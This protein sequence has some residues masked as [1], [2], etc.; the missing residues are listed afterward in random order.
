MMTTSKIAK[1][2]WLIASTLIM[3]MVGLAQE[4]QF[5]GKAEIQIAHTDKGLL[6]YT[7]MGTQIDAPF[8]RI[9]VKGEHQLKPQLNLVYKYEVQVKGFEQDDT[10]NPFAARNTYLGVQSYLGTLL[11][12]RNDTRFKYSEGKFDLFNE[13]QGDIA[14]VI[15]GQD[16]IGDTITYVVPTWYNTEISMTYAPKDDA[17]SQ[18]SGY[19]ITAIYGD[20]S[21]QTLPY[22]VAVS[23]VDGLNNLVSSRA[24]GMMKMQKWQIGLL[25]Q[26][27][28]NVAETKSGHAFGMSVQFQ[29]DAWRPKLQWLRDTS[30]L[31][32]QGTT[33]NYSVGLDYVFDKSANAY[34]MLSRLSLENSSDVSTAVGL[35]YLF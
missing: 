26:E 33:T 2:H 18:Q 1:V 15:A 7:E 13:T 5:Y 28:K 34:I 3:P 27:A 32:H 29:H 19:A 10:N 22:S 11:V 8:S 21:L 14:Q 12:G 31:R 23:H 4:Y 24:I 35:K 20:R 17:N 30:E 25:W 9:G 16:R 6:R